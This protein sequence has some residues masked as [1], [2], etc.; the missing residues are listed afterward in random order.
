MPV[1]LVHDDVAEG[2]DGVHA[3]ARTERH[4]GGA[5]LDTAPGNLGVL[6]LERA[7]HIRDGQVVGP[8]AIGVE[9]HVDLPRA[10]TDDD[11]LADAADA[12]ELASQRLVRVFGDVANRRVRR[13]GERQHG[14]G[15]GIEFLD[16]RLIDGPRQQRQHAVDAVPDFLRGDVA[17]LLEQEG[18]DDLRDAFRRVRAQLVDAA[19]GVD[20][21]LDLVGDFRLDFLRRGARKAGGDDDGRKIDLRESIE[22]EPRECEG[23]DDCQRECDDRREDRST[24]GE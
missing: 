8:Q 7:G 10:S 17:I 5:L 14:R 9:Q 3:A 4:R 20:G 11:D 2:G 13:H 24:N 21:F 1:A 12:L 16:H 23:A 18:D 19:D 22:P 15:V 6:R